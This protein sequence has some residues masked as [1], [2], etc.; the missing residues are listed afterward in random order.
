MEVFQQMA[1][2]SLVM[3]LLGGAL[4]LLRRK[5]YAGVAVLKKGG[6]RRL[7]CVERLALGP[8]HALHLVRVG[9]TEILLAS[10]PAGCVLLD[11]LAGNRPGVPR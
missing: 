10:S 8:Q 2:V 5:G 3:L 9:E 11:Y 4:W 7:E 1:A 6:A